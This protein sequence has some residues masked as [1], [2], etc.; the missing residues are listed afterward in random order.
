MS[1]LKGSG[2]GI[3]V[4][5]DVKGLVE[6]KRALSR[7]VPEG[8]KELMKGVI[9]AALMVENEAKAMIQRG[10]RSGRIYKRGKITH[11]ASAPGEPPKSDQANLVR[12]ITTVPEAADLSATVGS[13]IAAAYGYLL[14]L[15]TSKMAPRP[16]LEPALNKHIDA[17]HARLVKAWDDALEKVKG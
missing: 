4:S 12:N 5:V 15:G 16:W 6:T 10:G 2:P 3:L 13:R 17:I 7:L 8:K 11:Q 14:E 1:Q 9:A